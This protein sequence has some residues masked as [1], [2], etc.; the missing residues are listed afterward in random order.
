VSRDEYDKAREAA[1]RELEEL[2]RQ[3]ADLDKRIG[4]L[5]QAIGNLLRLSGLTP[6]VSLGLTDA[7]RM[8][9]RSAGAPLTVLEVRAQL[10]AMGI[11]LS[12]YENDLAAIHTILKRLNQAGEIRFVPR[13]WGRPSYEWLFPHVHVVG[14]K[15]VEEAVEKFEKLQPRGRWKGGGRMKRKTPAK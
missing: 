11:D 3:R 14:V 5:M 8:V 2:T 15:S 13:S 9:L 4:Q 6:T 7:C 1:T 12:R 10:A